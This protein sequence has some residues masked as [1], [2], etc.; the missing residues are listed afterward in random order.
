RHAAVAACHRS[1]SKP[2]HTDFPRRR[3]A[4]ACP[5]SQQ[6]K[7][8]RG[9][10]LLQ[11][12]E[13]AR[14]SEGEVEAAA[15]H[16]GSAIR[17]GHQNGAPVVQVRHAH[18][19]AERQ[20]AMRCRQLFRPEPAATGSLP[21]G[22]RVAVVGCPA[23]TGLWILVRSQVCPHRHRPEKAYSER[24]YKKNGPGDRSPGPIG[25][26]LHDPAPCT[27]T[28][29]ADGF[30]TKTLPV[31]DATRAARDSPHTPGSSAPLSRG[32][33]VERFSIRGAVY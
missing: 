30:G 33:G 14:R 28:K 21:P 15:A 13:L 20:R 4:R 23:E 11:H 2:E 9:H 5:T 19:G 6:L 12:A 8:N 22:E 27:P 31:S 16:V 18:L 1:A 26:G 7:Q 32:F 24:E 10:T 3:H 25:H 29:L 17:D